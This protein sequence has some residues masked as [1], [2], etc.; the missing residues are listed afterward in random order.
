MARTTPDSDRIAR[1]LAALEAAWGPTADAAPIEIVRAPGRANLMGDHTEHNEGFVLPIAIELDTWIAVRPRGDGLVRIASRHR[2]EVGSFRIDALELAPGCGGHA[3]RPPAGIAAIGP[4][5]GAAPAAAGPCGGWS[6][7]V[8][9][10][11]WSLREAAL[12]VRGFDG[13][14]DTTIPF[15]AELAS[16]AALEVASA[17]ALLGSGSEV[18][19]ASLAV[20]A[21]RGESDYLGVDCGFMDQFASAAGRADRAVLLDCRSLEARHVSLPYGLRVVICDTGS[22]NEGGAAPYLTRRAECAR[23]LALLAE[24]VPGLCSI[25]DLDAAM[26]RRH[27]SRLPENVARRAEHVVSENARVLATVAALEAG[28][29]DQLGRLFAESHAS[30]RDLYEVSS[31]ALDTMVEVAREIPGVV[32]A[33][34]TGPGF[35]GCTVNLVLADAVPALQAAVGREYDSRTGLKACA[36]PVAIVD[37]AG[38]VVTN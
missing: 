22:R 23:A 14:V 18:P 26:L 28:D 35:G 34:M 8:A 5:S 30:L 10:T 24:R 2:P 12:P 6:D 16:S 1:L 21:Q 38:P 27:R 17:L 33:R 13:V 20:L 37:G 29:L 32:A 36:Y 25:R 31:P 19:A 3:G 9:A 7:Y 15:G 4:G 11:A